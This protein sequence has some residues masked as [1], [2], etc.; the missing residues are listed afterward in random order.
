MITPGKYCVLFKTPIGEGPG[1]VDLDSE[2][3]LTGGD[4]TFSYVG[5][6][7]QNGDRFKA[8]LCARRTSPG[9]PGVFGVDEVDIVVAG[10]SN[11]GHPW[12]VPA[13]PDRH[14]V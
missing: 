4:S 7:A 8:I 6:W 1:V 10:R 12:S 5:T 3:K 14:R 13:L 2:G 11:G 9:P